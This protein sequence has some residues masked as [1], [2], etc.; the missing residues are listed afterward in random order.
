MY[1][2][3]TTLD[4][5]IVHSSVNICLYLLLNVFTQKNCLWF[6]ICSRQYIA[7]SWGWDCVKNFRVHFSELLMTSIGLFG[8]YLQPPVRTVQRSRVCFKMMS[9][10]KILFDKMFTIHWWRLEFNPQS[11]CKTSCMTGYVYNYRNEELERG[12][13]PG[14]ALPS[15]FV[16]ISKAPCPERDLYQK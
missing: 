10:D 7:I 15:Q 3:Y 13:F 4:F 16:L 11:P 12:R 1:N 14:A 6:N 8:G 9:L 5:V 2:I